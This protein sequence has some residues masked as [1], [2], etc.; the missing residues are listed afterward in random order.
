MEMRQLRG[1]DLKVSRLCFGTM[2][3]GKPVDDATARNM[4][5]HC[6]DAGINFFDTANIYQT[7]VAESY[8]G[9]ALKGRRDKVILATKVHGSM[10]PAP[11]Q[12]GLSRAAI[13]RAVEE[14]LRR[15]QTDYLDLYYLHQPDY[16]VPVE[17]TFA[18]MDELVRAGKVRWVG[19][20]NYASWQMC[21]ML[22]LADRHG[23]KPAPIAQQMYNLIARG[24]EQ[25]FIPFAKQKNVSVI[26]Y[27]PLAGGLLT[28]KH[29]PSQIIPGT[30]FDDNRMY[31]DRYWHPKNFEAVTALAEIA[32][33]AGRSL[34]S[35]AFGWLLHQ[36]DVDCVILGAS[37][38]EQLEQNLAACR[39]GPIAPELIRECDEVWHQLRGPFPMY[40]R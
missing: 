37:R 22:H 4:V 15:L 24:L 38:P 6:M 7:G 26:A 35:L 9:N 3:F 16:A 1:T 40:N 30:R 10:G 29:S 33:K 2:T 23:Y 20:S 17:E 31:Q 34:I 36:E 25:E 13:H 12:H 28:G 19:T 32:R 14:S 11:D 21:E 18:T 39:E 27:N 8:L 5:S